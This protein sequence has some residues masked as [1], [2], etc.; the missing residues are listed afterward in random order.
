MLI[1]AAAFVKSIVSYFFPAS[2]QMANTRIGLVTYSTAVTPQFNLSTFSTR[3]DLFCAVD[4]MSRSTGLTYTADAL[5]YA[6]TVMFT[7]AACVASPIASV[8]PILLQ[9]CP[10]PELRQD[11]RAHHGRRRIRAAGLR[12]QPLRRG[13]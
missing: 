1:F 8:E 6:K 13:H 11:H 9:R 7:P 5:Y 12:T 3:D 2:T 4:Q 10:R